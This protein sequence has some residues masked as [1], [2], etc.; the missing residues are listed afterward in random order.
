MDEV[1]KV[2]R[3]SAK[4]FSD[5]FWGVLE[6]FVPILGICNKKSGKENT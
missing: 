6:A 4:S 3:L 2:S 1:D 5:V